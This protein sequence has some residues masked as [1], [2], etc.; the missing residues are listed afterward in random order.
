MSMRLIKTCGLCLLVLLA[1]APAARA[2]NE[3]E[4]DGV[5]Y[6]PSNLELEGANINIDYHDTYGF[7]VRYGHRFSPPFGI[8]A[9]WTHVDLDS[10]SDNSVGCS[11]CNFSVD[12]A[13]FS[14][15]WYP[16]GSNLGLYAGLG[17]ASGDFEV[18]I[19]GVSNDR[20]ISDDAFTWHLGA[21][22]A[23]QVGQAFYVRPDVRIRFL[24]LDQSGRGKYDSEDPQVGLGFGW[25]F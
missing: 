18:N 17:W 24:Q 12:F 4:V 25:R 1:M 3:I 22:W 8:G 2:S 14:F 11:T 16:G 10:A 13:D 21:A 20:K 6:F 23:W 19:P 15:E 9:S 7:G 5:W